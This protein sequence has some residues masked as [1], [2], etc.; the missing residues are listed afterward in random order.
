MA[1]A[2]LPIN[3][4]DIHSIK[5][6]LDQ[7][8]VKFVSAKGYQINH[9]Y[10]NRKLI[11]GWIAVFVATFGH[12]Y[13][14]P[15]PESHRVLCM[16]VLI[17]FAL[18]WTI[19]AQTWFVEQDTILWAHPKGEGPGLRVRAS[20]RRFSPDYTVSFEHDLKGSASPN[21]SSATVQVDRFFDTEG[22]V[23]ADNFTKALDDLW[24]EFQ[25]EG[26]KAK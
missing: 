11:M 22:H 3:L 10:N 8:A 20:L 13:W 17:Y 16:C 6:T 12:F 24:K 19:Q 4:M 9:S 7:E 1:K 21:K 15:Y 25:S 26:K 18:H 2:P 5:H 23:V 14:V